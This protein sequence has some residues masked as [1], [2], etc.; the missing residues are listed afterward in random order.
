MTSIG[1]C[2]TAYM[3]ALGMSVGSVTTLHINAI[4]VYLCSSY[5]TRHGTDQHDCTTSRQ[6]IRRYTLQ[7]VAS[8]DFLAGS[9]A[10]VIEP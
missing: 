4:F 1:I 6:H 3:T 2:K 5:A 10:V 7:A 9:L 8:W